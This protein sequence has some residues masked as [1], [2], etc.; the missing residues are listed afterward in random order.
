MS[1]LT[2]VFQVVFLVDRVPSFQPL[3]ILNHL[4]WF[5]NQTVARLGVVDD[6]GYITFSRLGWIQISGVSPFSTLFNDPTNN[7]TLLRCLRD[8]AIDEFL[9]GMETAI[10]SY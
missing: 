7:E 10:Q 4:R 6:P 1:F 3:L 5:R 9:H 8:D 2:T